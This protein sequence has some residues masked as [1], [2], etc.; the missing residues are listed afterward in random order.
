[1]FSSE[2]GEQAVFKCYWKKKTC[3]LHF[4]RHYTQVCQE[5]RIVNGTQSRRQAQR[6]YSERNEAIVW[7]EEHDMINR[8]YQLKKST[9]RM[10]SSG[11][12]PFEDVNSL[13]KQ[14]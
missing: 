6:T 3:A 4:I 11:Y 9:S 14:N 1:M 12:L 8:M 2:S 7:W 5:D 10:T 13:V